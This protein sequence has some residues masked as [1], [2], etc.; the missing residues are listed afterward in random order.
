V[1]D[2]ESRLT[3]F[4]S[5]PA[6]QAKVVEETGH[7]PWPLPDDAWVQA[8]TWEALLFAHWPMPVDDLR[9]HV[10]EELPLDTFDG[11]AWIGVTPFRVSGLRVRGVPPLPYFSSF[12]ELNVR[13]YVELDGKAGIWFFSLDAESSFAVEAARRIYRLPYFRARMSAVAATEIEYA[14]ERTEG[15]PAAFRGRYGPTGDAVPPAPGSLEHFLAE[16]YCLFTMHEGRVHWAE[17]HHLPW[18]LQP[19]EAEIAENTMP[20]PGIELR[21]DPLCHYS[22]RQDTVLWGLERFEP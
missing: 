11:S 22:G 7:R 18:Q 14:S 16:R 4:L 15:R 10:P 5:T 9:Q 20:P 12:L 19:A 6:R 1:Q 21:G 13:T 2:L 8:Q 3:E 17:I